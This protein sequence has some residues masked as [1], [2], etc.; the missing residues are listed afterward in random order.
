MKK[1]SYKEELVVSSGINVQLFP[2]IYI[3]DLL[4][5][6]YKEDLSVNLVAGYLQ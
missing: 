5:L 3:S 4:R 2:G 6:R 1:K